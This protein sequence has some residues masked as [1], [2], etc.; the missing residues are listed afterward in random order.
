MANLQIYGIIAGV[1]LL[2]LGGFYWYYTSSQAERALLIANNAKLQ[3]AVDLNEK[4]IKE[5]QTKFERI[6]KANV[7]LSA[8]LANAEQISAEER[9]LLEEQNYNDLT[10]QE[11]ERRIN[12]DY[13]RNNRSLG[14]R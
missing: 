4:T 14:A 9:K 7:N 2:L 8:R 6:I 13:S 11:I 12:E 5:M 3:V 1:F 10:E